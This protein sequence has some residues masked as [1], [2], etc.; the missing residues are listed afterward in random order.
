MDRLKRAALHRQATAHPTPFLASDAAAEAGAD[1][2]SCDQCGAG[3]FVAQPE[4]DGAEICITCGCIRESSHQSAIDDDAPGVARGGGSLR[5]GGGN[6]SR[7]D[8]DKMLYEIDLRTL[9]DTAAYTALSDALLVKVAG[10]LADRKQM[11]GRRRT[12]W[13]F[14]RTMIDVAA[15]DGVPVD[16]RM[17]ASMFALQG[18]K[19]I[20]ANSDANSVRCPR[21]LA[22]QYFTECVGL[23]ERLRRKPLAGF[24]DAGAM[25]RAAALLD[26]DLRGEMRYVRFVEAYIAESLCQG[27]CRRRQIR[28]RVLGACGV[29]L[30]CLG[31]PSVQWLADAS[32]K[33][34]TAIAGICR[35]LLGSWRLFQ[36]VHDLCG[37]P[38]PPTDDGAAA[39]GLEEF[40]SRDIVRVLDRA[41]VPEF[42][43][44]RELV[45]PLR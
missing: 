44:L 18:N 26:A 39:M 41:V 31:Y 23:A 40:A 7:E 43:A 30:L 37:V 28:T 24:A 10:V 32:G 4:F 9:R 3:A 1:L 5:F 38:Y 22:A 27:R 25:Q 35:E 16:R 12:P 17:V 21:T 19:T 34:K 33:R 13:L 42:A 8:T 45:A 2:R 29:L 36:H 15:K 20:S 6:M 11:P 14:A